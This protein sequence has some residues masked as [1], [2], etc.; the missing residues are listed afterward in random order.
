MCFLT[1]IVIEDICWVCI[2]IMC[3]EKKYNFFPGKGLIA[4]PIGRGKICTA[5]KLRLKKKKVFSPFGQNSKPSTGI[6][7]IKIRLLFNYIDI[8]WQEHFP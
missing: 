8:F 4:S 3:N 1:I 6:H 5:I 7:L 2:V